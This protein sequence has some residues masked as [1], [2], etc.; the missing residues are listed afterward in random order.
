MADPPST[1]SPTTP[2][3]RLLAA[4]QAEEWMTP[5]SIVVAIAV[6]VHSHMVNPK[7]EIRKWKKPRLYTFVAAVGLLFTGLFLLAGTCITIRQAT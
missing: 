1:D 6:L 5:V 3:G 7:Q 2:S 4:L